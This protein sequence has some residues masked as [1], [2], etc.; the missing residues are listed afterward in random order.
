MSYWTLLST[1][2]KAQLLYQGE[3]DGGLTP[4]LWHYASRAMARFVKAVKEEE[5]M[6]YVKNM[7][8]YWRLRLCRTW[9][10]LYPLIKRIWE[11]KTESCS[12]LSSFIEDLLVRVVLVE[13]WN[14]EL[15]KEVVLLPDI[16]DKHE[17]VTLAGIVVSSI[18]HHG[19]QRTC[20]V[21]IDVLHRVMTAKEVEV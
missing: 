15:E 21:V 13:E 17:R 16:Q 4:N 7:D 1:L 9:F 20:D 10:K 2:D 14:D 8:D 11:G 6:H 12:T 5:H 18:Q 19:V 3:L